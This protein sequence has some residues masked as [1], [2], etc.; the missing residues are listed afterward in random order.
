MYHCAQCQNGA[1]NDY[2]LRYAH[3]STCGRNCYD[4]PQNFEAGVA[5]CSDFC[6]DVRI[7]AAVDQERAL[8]YAAS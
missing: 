8:E 2:G 4:E 7:L 3:C 5:F 6:A 1:V